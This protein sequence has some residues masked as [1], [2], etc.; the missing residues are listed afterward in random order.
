MRKMLQMSALALL[1]GAAFA[2]EPVASGSAAFSFVPSGCAAASSASEGFSYRWSVSASSDSFAYY[3]VGSTVASD[4][5]A[6][7]AFQ[8]PDCETVGGVIW[9]YVLADGGVIIVNTGGT[10]GVGRPSGEC[11][12][13]ASLG[14]YPVKSIGCGALRNCT[15]LTTVVVPQSVTNVEEAAFAGCAAL[16]SVELPGSVVAVGTAAFDGC[17]NLV[18]VVLPPNLSAIA[19]QTFRG[20]AALK[21]LELPAGIRLVDEEAF[22]ECASL[23]AVVLPKTLEKIGIR[24]FFGC[25]S[26]GALTAPASVAELGE[27]AFVN[28]TALG[29][30]SFGGQPPKGIW[31]SGLVND[32]TE[33][34]GPAHVAI[35][36]ADGTV[37]G[38]DL[39]VT[40]STD[41]E[42]GVV[43]YTLDGSE[44]T[45][46][47]P[48]FDGISIHGKTTVRAATFVDGLRWSEIAEATYGVGQ[49]ETPEI[50]SSMGETFSH[51][52][53]VITLSCATRGV[54]IRYTL[55]GG[56][57]TAN[58]A[59]YTG[60]FEISR[61]T[62]VRA[63]AFG[64]SDY[65]DSD[66][67]SRQFVRT[68]EG[69]ATP[70]ISPAGC[71]FAAESR[72]VA[73]AC[74]SDGVTIYY[75]LDGS[76]PS[77]TNGRVYT[78]P[79][80]V[81]Q[82][83]TVRAIA[84]RYDWQ[85]SDVATAAFARENALSEALN[86][87]GAKVTN[88]GTHPWTVD[89]HV[90][91]DGVGSVRSAAVTDG[92]SC[93]KLTVKGAGRLSFWWKASCESAWDGDCY[94][95]GRFAVEGV[96]TVKIAGKTD[97]RL[98]TTNIATTGKHV[99]SWEYVKDSETD[100]GDDCI[101]VDQ[102]VWVP[103]DGSG[104]T[105]TA[106]VP[107]PY[108]WLEKYGLGT[109]TD[110][111]TAANAKTGKRTAHGRELEVWEDYVAGTDPT[112]VTSVFTSVIE[113]ISGKPKIT[114]SPDLNE[115]GTKAERVYKVWGSKTLDGQWFEVD[116][117]E[118]DYNFFTVS[119]ELP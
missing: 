66:V 72:Q 94:D 118:A 10:D 60:P 8:L 84:T 82:S 81:W 71:V 83:V 74:E 21:E 119:V 11:V 28:C 104:A 86:F 99:L 49:V 62:T 40:L 36:P 6:P 102:V 20:C 96:E 59:L 34:H 91:H 68:W 35:S 4:D 88:D 108:A 87:Y 5:S 95:Y 113:M 107:V 67:V 85:D 15:D 100:E 115:G 33:L 63:K 90:S 18:S 16:E 51:N 39:S 73:I 110:F 25:R 54:E 46:D 50:A 69:L 14:G 117:N 56:E 41:W 53:N 37:F 47:S 109:A 31:T 78:G 9:R 45:A 55:N 89:A 2:A 79:F 44:P 65:V 38:L 43:R 101:W 29:R 19:P 114:W 12:I 22:A 30:V 27:D 52:G 76:K 103:A 116:G 26:L 13:P 61:T 48:A 97:W 93:I 57:P 112:N 75:T 77:A 106:G 1:A 92:S 3:P 24:A 32:R 58:S 7:F 80:D 42:G 70:T 111:E 105:L 23:H 98:F 17:S 64:H